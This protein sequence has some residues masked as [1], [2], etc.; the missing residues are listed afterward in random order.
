MI[1][2][3]LANKSAQIY[4]LYAFLSQNLAQCGQKISTN[5]LTKFTV[6]LISAYILF[7]CCTITL[8]HLWTF[9]W[10]DNS[11]RHC[12]ATLTTQGS[13]LKTWSVVIIR[14]NIYF[15]EST[16]LINL[17]RTRVR[18]LATL[19]SNLLTHSL[20][21]WLTDCRL[22]DLIDVTLACQGPARV[23]F[24]SPRSEKWK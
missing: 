11:D 2:H 23:G 21:H 20:T 13:Q 6:F 17:Y 4:K 8:R 19:V 14:S 24:W 15:F 3:S 9:A 5:R 16:C 22:V 12:P 7:V 18:S 10:E 1:Q